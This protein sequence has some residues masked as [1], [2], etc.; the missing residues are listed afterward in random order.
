[1]HIR[2]ITLIAALL[3]LC[4]LSVRATDIVWTNLAGGNWSN[5]TNWSPNT[6]PGATDTALI[7]NAGTYTVTLNVAAAVTNL[8]IGGTNGLQTL[9]N[10]GF[11]LTLNGASFVGTNGVFAMD[12]GATLTGNGNLIVQGIL[13]WTGG[14]MSGTGRTIVTNGATL[15]I[16]GFSYGKTLHRYLDLYGNGSVSAPSVVAGNGVFFNVYGS[17]TLDFSAD[18][19]IAYSGAGAF[20]TLS[21]NGLVR[22]TA[23]PSITPVAMVLNNTGTVRSQSG[24][25]SFTGGGLSS[26]L[27]DAISNAVVNFGGGTHTL[28][29][30]IS[31]TASG[32]GYHRCDS[33]TLA[34]EVPYT[35]NPRFDL[36]AGGVLG[37][38]QNVNFTSLVN[39][40]GGAMSGTGRTIVT[41][42][43]TLNIAGFAYGKTLHRN[44]D[45]YGNGL[46][47]GFGV[48]GGLGVQFN[49]FSGAT[50]DFAADQHFGYS[51]AGALASLLNSGTVRK[52][53]GASVANINFAVTNNGTFSSQSGTLNFQNSYRQNSGLTTLAGGGFQALLLDINGGSLTGSGNISGPVRNNGATAPGNAIGQITLTGANNFTNTAA[54]SY[55]IQLGGTNRGTTYDSIA[56]GGTAV[57][58]GSLNVSF[59][60]GFVP[61]IGSIYTAM[62]YTA[63]SGAF[64]NSNAGLLGMVELYTPTNFLL[65]A[66]N[67]LPQVS[68]TVEAGATQAVCRPFYLSAQAFD[69]DGS[70]TNLAILVNGSP[71]VSGTNTFAETTLEI[72]YPGS[73]VVEARAYDDKGALAVSNRPVELSVPLHVLTLGGIR[74]TNDFKLCMIGQTGSNYMVQATTN[75]TVPN[76]TNWANIG[77]MS[78][79]NGVFRYFDNGVLTS[80][81]PARYY[82]AKQE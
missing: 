40:T 65:I 59:T 48:N 39:W 61:P 71:I 14:A 13:N 41:N 42:G 16:A 34:F 69:L 31:F 58:S 70:I 60:N 30:G 29:N 54:G 76:T 74:N 4:H 25:L 80:N 7:T 5:A 11:A 46:L 12:A 3:C 49:V 79:T 63:R 26:G 6:V 22:K 23:G 20:A 64:T 1:M 78:Y 45:L 53:A 33:G 43:A 57:L 44:L 32:G 15:N 21:N 36:D 51:G 35:F 66:S 56:V 28:T 62:T 82:R 68:F 9:A 47:T 52:T 10:A 37:G 81:F 67:G 27:F 8:T 2:R 50:F 75:L 72:D 55:F 18:Y 17:A 19:G 38:S 24:T 73:Y 77:L